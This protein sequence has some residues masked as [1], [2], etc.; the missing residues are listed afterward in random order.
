MVA[1]M[2]ADL[3][4]SIID[5]DLLAREVVE[6][7]RPALRA[8]VAHCGAVVPAAQIAAAAAFVEQSRAYSRNAAIKRQILQDHAATFASLGD[9][10]G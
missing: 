7:G 6:P 4:A 9:R 2:L 5:A 1:R 3:G 10:A 8:I